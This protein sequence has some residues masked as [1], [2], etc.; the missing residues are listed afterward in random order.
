MSLAYDN[1]AWPE[2]LSVIDN[3]LAKAPGF[4]HGQHTCLSEGVNATR[5]ALMPKHKRYQKYARERCH[6]VVLWH[7]RGHRAVQDV[8]ESV[9]KE[10]DALNT[11]QQAWIEARAQE[12]AKQAEYKARPEVRKRDACKATER[13]RR[14]A[15]AKERSKQRK[16]E[17]HKG[18]GKGDYTLMHAAQSAPARKRRSQDTLASDFDRGDKGL[19]RCSA[20]KHVYTSENAALHHVQGGNP[21]G[22]ACEKQCARLLTNE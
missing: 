14:A 2:L 11:H 10:N 4:C 20:C 7:N 18:G 1:P 19:F 22:K 13:W 5:A 21:K 6:W 3:V 15:E 9:Y 16:S 17:E 12:H 8:L